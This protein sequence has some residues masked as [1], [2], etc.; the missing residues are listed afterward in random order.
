[1][2]AESTIQPAI[3]YLAQGH[4]RVKIGDQPPRTIDSAFGNTIRQK[5]IRSQQKNSWKSVSDGSPFSGAVLWGK[6]VM[7]DNVPLAITSICS[8]NQSRQLLYSLESGSLC[9]LLDVCGDEEQRLWNDNRRNPIF[10]LPDNADT[11][12]AVPLCM[13]SLNTFRMR[14]A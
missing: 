2:S 11:V 7:D 6:A 9:A 4:I 3:T 5:A 1:M 13:P 8:G 10:S 14:K 12:C